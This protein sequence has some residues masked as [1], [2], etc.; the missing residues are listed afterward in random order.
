ML[1]NSSNHPLDNPSEI[2][3]STLSNTILPSPSTIKKMLCCYVVG[4]GQVNCCW[5]LPAQIT[6]VPI[7]AGLVAIFYW[8]TTL[9][10]MQLSL[11][12]GQCLWHEFVDISLICHYN[13]ILTYRYTWALRPSLAQVQHVRPGLSYLSLSLS[14][15]VRLTPTSYPSTTWLPLPVSGRKSLLVKDLQVG[16]VCGLSSPVDEG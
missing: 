9:G 11:L 13:H 16:A 7:P 6:L 4:S 8:L 3:N 5:P 15:S 10:V 2:V 1:I 12:C 14:L